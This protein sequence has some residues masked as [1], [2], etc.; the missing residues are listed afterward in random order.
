MPVC[1]LELL[2]IEFHHLDREERHEEYLQT[3]EHLFRA[4]FQVLH[5]H[6][7]TQCCGLY[8]APG[9]YAI[10]KMIEVTL[11]SESEALTTCQN[12][13]HLSLDHSNNQSDF[14]DE[15][16]VGLA[17]LPSWAKAYS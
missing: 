6:G 13:T 11:D 2:R 9:G 4:G 7:N 5:L 8:Q 3:M 15:Q 12:E 10:P 1:T 17:R 16:T 14:N